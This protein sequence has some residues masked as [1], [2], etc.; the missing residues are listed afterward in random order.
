MQPSGYCALLADRT[1]QAIPVSLQ[2]GPLDVFAL[3][4]SILTAI[5]TVTAVTIAIVV[6][7]RD[8]RDRRRAQASTISVW[9]MRMDPRVQPLR[10]G[11][12]ISN[13]S[14][15][16]IFEVVITIAG[17]YGSADP[18]QIEAV[19]PVC[20]AKVPPG[21]WY[22]EGPHHEGG[23]AGTSVDAAITFTDGAGLWWQRDAGGTL[24]RCF[25]RPLDARGVG[26]PPNWSGIARV[27]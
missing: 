14:Q 8:S 24:S 9:S 19:M 18:M 27:S 17:V 10:Y 23:S 26:G 7:T 22:V 21:D 1:G 13:G 25:E 16:T 4:V 6:A 20:V 2:T 11:L 5:A 3:C 15:A 12:V